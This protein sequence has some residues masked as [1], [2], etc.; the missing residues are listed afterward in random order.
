MG[1][2]RGPA[3]VAIMRF[4]IRLPEP[5]PPMSWLFG[6]RDGSSYVELDERGL[7]FCYGTADERVP[8]QEIGRVH[9]DTWPLEFGLGARTGPEDTVAYVGSAHGVVRVEFLRPRP[10]NVWGAFE[11]PNAR[12]AVVS[13]EDPSAFLDAIEAARTRG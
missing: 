13:L 1:S 2:D 9:P 10:M 8:L 6:F 7:R 12:A 3:G 5:F 4:P 11:L